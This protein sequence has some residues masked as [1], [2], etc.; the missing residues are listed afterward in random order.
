MIFF[1]FDEKKK[2]ILI[3][4]LDIGK[5]GANSRISNIL[6]IDQKESQIQL[7]SD[8]K[9]LADEITGTYGGL[10]NIVDSTHDL[11]LGI[12]QPIA[13]TFNVHKVFVA[14]RC[15]YFKTFLNDPFR[16]IEQKSESDSETQGNIA[17]IELNDM[18]KDVLKEILYFIYSDDFSSKNVIFRFTYDLFLMF[19]CY[20]FVFSWMKRFCL[21]FC[22]MLTCTCWRV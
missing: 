11:C 1:C 16:E 22:S 4:I 5:Y 17:R 15:D 19:H 3:I 7:K 13:I 20:S 2:L 21:R 12:K 18:T 8:L 14:E 6:I 9:S 10:R